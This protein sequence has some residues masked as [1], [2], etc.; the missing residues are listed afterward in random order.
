[1]REITD[2]KQVEAWL[3]EGNIPDQFDT[4]GLPFRAYRYEKGELIVTPSRPMRHLLFLVAGRVLIYGIRRDGGMAPVDELDRPALLGDLEYCSGGHS[5]F[6]AQAKTQATFIALPADA[7]RALLD[8]DLRFLHMLLR[9]YAQKL[10]IFAFVDM[11]A[12]TIEERTLL[13]MPRQTP[14]HELNGTQAAAHQLRCSRR[15]LQRVLSALCA[16][17]R[18]ERTGR[19]SYRLLEP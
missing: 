19:G 18:V 5:A 9:S 8:R 6:Y 13:Y 14:G 11:A 16:S 15:Q 4:Q 12:P 17:G 2:R 7:C 1:M 3:R 10:S